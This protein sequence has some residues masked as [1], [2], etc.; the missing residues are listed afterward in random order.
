MITIFTYG[1]C[2]I[3]VVCYAST[4]FTISS[5]VFTKVKTKTPNIPYTSNP[6]SLVGGTMSLRGI[7]NH[8]QTMLLGKI[9]HWLHIYGMAE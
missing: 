9:K 7:L 5:Q 1:S 6:L 4:C 8:T 3:K 2:K